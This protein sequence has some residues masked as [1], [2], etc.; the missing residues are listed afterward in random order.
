MESAP[1]TEPLIEACKKINEQGYKIALDDH[2]FDS[3]WDPL[4]PYTSIVKVDVKNAAMGEIKKQLPKFA[5][6]GISLAAQKVENYEVLENC[7]DIGF[8]FFQG[9]FFAQPEI[10]RNREIPAAKM[11]LLQ[12]VS[13][14]A[15]EEMDYDK[16]VSYTHLRAHETV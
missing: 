12:L 4:L 3:K 14:S 2:D 5:R 15:K 7:K 9:Y 16:T 6:Y 11:S 1:V 8:D 10:V 13:E